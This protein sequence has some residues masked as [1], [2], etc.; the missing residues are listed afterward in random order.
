MNGSAYQCMSTQ[1]FGH[2]LQCIEARTVS[3]LEGDFSFD[4]DGHDGRQGETSSDKIMSEV[5]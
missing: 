3:S 1:M 2:R 5:Q 4:T